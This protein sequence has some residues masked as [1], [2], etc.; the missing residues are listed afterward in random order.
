MINKIK[1]KLYNILRYYTKKHITGNL[2]KVVED[3]DKI[4]CYVEKK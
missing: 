1:I 4:I 2:G 3:K